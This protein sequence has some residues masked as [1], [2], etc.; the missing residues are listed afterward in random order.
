MEREIKWHSSKRNEKCSYVLSKW[1]SRSE[2]LTILLE[3]NSLWAPRTKGIRLVLI[4]A[5]WFYYFIS[6]RS[7]WGRRESL[8]IDEDGVKSNISPRHFIQRSKSNIHI[9]V[10]RLSACVNNGSN[11]DI[12]RGKHQGENKNVNR[13]LTHDHYVSLSMNSHLKISLSFSHCIK[14]WWSNHIISMMKE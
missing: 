11:Q 12:K 9:L 1:H 6:D 13:N 14:K 3:L 5:G 4:S 8:N 10:F 7:R 2:A